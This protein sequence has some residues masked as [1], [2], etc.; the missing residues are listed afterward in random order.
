M[1]TLPKFDIDTF[2]QQDADDIFSARKKGKAVHKTKNI[3][4]AG[5]EIELPVKDIIKR[6]LPQ[7]YYVGQGHIVDSDLNTS[8][9]FDI[10]VG[11]N[12]GSPILFSTANNTDYL[13]Y[14]SIYA[15]GE[16]KS[17]YYKDK[18]YVKDFA[19]KTKNVNE[20]L[21]RAKTPREQLT[22]DLIF[23]TTGPITITTG[24]ERPYKNPLFKFMFFVDS[25]DLDLSQLGVVL[26]SYANID[27]PNVMCFLDRGIVLKAEA[28]LDQSAG[29]TILSEVQTDTN[30]DVNEIIASIQMK[31]KWKLGSVH[32]F[33]E[34]IPANKISEYKWVLYEFEERLTPASCLAYLIYA[35]NN[36]LRECMV[37]KPDLLKYHSKLFK[38]RQ[39][40]I[41]H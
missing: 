18:H 36:H 2:F 41:M 27:L 13:T 30:R 33:P 12:K 39:A 25:G 37:L 5:D 10:I 7:Q 35:L 29:Q 38:I 16:I 31:L 19:E 4:A 17:T 40:Y 22:Q 6:R 8:G 9:Q 28:T 14:E 34:F 1:S 21:T 15:V 32:L 11:D 26:G 24:D 23:N 3:D 20:H